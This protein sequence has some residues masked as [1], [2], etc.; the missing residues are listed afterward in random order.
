MLTSYLESQRGHVDVLV[1]NG[2]KGRTPQFAEVIVQ[3]ERSRSVGEVVR[4][5]ITRAETQR[6]VG[7]ACA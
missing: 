7:E 6:L 1:E 3:G 5:Q 4:T 2:G